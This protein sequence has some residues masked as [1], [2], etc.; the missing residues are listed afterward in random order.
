MSATKIEA[1]IRIDL[2]KVH[3]V[4]FRDNISARCGFGDGRVDAV[5]VCGV[6]FRDTVAA[7]CN[8]G[9]RWVDGI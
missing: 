9:Y 1:D 3:R 8:S 5:E 7:R 6:G 2:I 4:R